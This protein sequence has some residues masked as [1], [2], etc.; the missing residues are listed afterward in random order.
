MSKRE[1]IKVKKDGSCIVTL[2]ERMNA[3]TMKYCVETE[4]GDWD[5]MISRNFTYL[6][7][8]VT[9]YKNQGKKK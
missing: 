1:V 5:S 3:M 7:L 6:H 8:A 4:N 9:Y 2:F